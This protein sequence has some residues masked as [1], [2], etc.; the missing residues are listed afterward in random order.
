ME[1]SNT[2]SPIEAAERLGYSSASVV[3]NMVIKSGKF[4]NAF[5]DDKNRWRIPFS[6][7]ENFERE[8]EKSKEQVIYSSQS[9]FEEIRKYTETI[10][11]KKDLNETAKLYLEY[12]LLQTN[13]MRGSNRYKRDAILSFQRFYKSLV[14]SIDKEVYLLSN[15]EI[16]EFLDDHSPFGKK[17]KLYFTRFL[18]YSYERKNIQDR[19]DYV[20]YHRNRKKDIKDIYSP[21]EFH[22]LYKHCKDVIINIPHAL[23][24]SYYANMWVYTILLLTDFIRGHD[25]IAH[26][27]NI[28]LEELNIPSLNWFVENTLSETQSQLVIRQLYLHYRHKRSSK[29]DELLTFIVAPDLAYPLSLALVISE[30]HRRMEGRNFLLDTFYQGVYNKITTHAKIRHKRFLKS[31]PSLSDFKFSSRKMNRTVSTYLFFSITEGDEYDSEL[32]LHLTQTARSHKAPDTTSVYIQSTNKDGTINRVSFNLF[33]RGHFGWLFNYLIL[34]ASQNKQL[35]STLE[36]RTK[37]IEQIR[38]EVSPSSLESVAKFINNYLTSTPIQN[39]SS[40]QNLL[41]G[42]YEK[43]RS[44]VSKL[45][46]FSTDEINDILGKLACGEMP[47][48]NEH[49]QCL[50]Y[51]DCAYPRLTNCYSCEYILPRNLLLIQLKEDLDRLIDNIQSTD[52]EFMIRKET[53]FLLHTLL[54]WKEARIAY[55]EDYVRAYLSPTSTWSKLEEIAHK[56]QLDEY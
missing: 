6:D 2:L 3:W 22:T 35:N 27:P 36:E 8:R 7:I 19:E 20:I 11:V 56:L 53:K 12:C 14:T 32:A 48:K 52:N 30:F 47:S 55:G 54:V 9:S 40:V 21:Q 18:R 46:D 38:Q 10:P 13:N 45:A 39:N 24:D 1:K 34:Y 42:I 31:C 33:K 23:E 17:E 44:A 50:V 37:L 29:T 49:A 41:S 16:S 4:P 51:P 28:H 15:T 25:L 5:K 43:R 26:T